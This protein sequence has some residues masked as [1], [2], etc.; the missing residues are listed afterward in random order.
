[1]L[2]I[3]RYDVFFDKA[4]DLSGFIEKEANLSHQENC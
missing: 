2:L 3:L 4:V 1:M